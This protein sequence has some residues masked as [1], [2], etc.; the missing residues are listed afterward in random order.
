[1]RR[2]RGVTLLEALVALAVTALVLGA[3]SR[4]LAGATRVRNDAAAGADRTAAARTVLL[5]LAAEIEAAAPGGD[6]VVEPEGPG[7]AAGARLRLTTLVRDAPGPRPTTDRRAVAWAVDPAS[8]TLVRREA[9]RP[10]PE[11]ALPPPLAVLDGVV[12][13]GVRCTDGG[14]WRPRWAAGGPLP[15]AIALSLALDDGRGGTEELATT[16][17]VALGG[18]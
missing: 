6:F 3:L 11:D 8:R 12:R 9:L 2:S 14:T 16:V 18:R 1:M 17:T 5:R 15:R 4:A 10:A 7:V 13:L